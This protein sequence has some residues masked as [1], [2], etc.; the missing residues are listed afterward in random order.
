M[1]QL[2]RPNTEPDF[3]KGDGLIIAIA[4]DIASGAVL[5]VAYMDRE[6]YEKTL[7]TGEM[8]YRS[9][10]RG[11][12]HKGATSGHIQT[13][14]SLTLDCDNDAILAQ[15]TSNGP[16]CHTGAPTCF[17]RETSFT[18]AIAQLAQVI[19]SRASEQ[20]TDQ[21]AK[22]STS[23][24]YTTKLLADKN[25]RLKKLGEEITELVVALTE[26]DTERATEEASDVLYH[27]LVA[28]RAEGI[29]LRDVNSVLQSRAK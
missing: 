24:S 15:V 28:L 8:Y 26:H 27:M 7:E 9:R 19:E 11:L 21:T 18:S 10:T 5:M 25:L 4:Q 12:W 17:G 22:Q 6:A 23:P 16:A 13:V 3:E 14:H 2:K 20:A 1:S 29:R